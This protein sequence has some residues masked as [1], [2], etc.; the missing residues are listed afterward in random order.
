MYVINFLKNLNSSFYADGVDK[1][2][3]Q[4]YKFL[5]SSD[6]LLR[7]EDIFNSNSV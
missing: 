6:N 7:N 1:L 2:V 4:Y 5:D 3:L